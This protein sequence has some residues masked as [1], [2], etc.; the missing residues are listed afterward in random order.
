MESESTMHHD[1]NAP[2][3]DLDWSSR[4]GDG[5]LARMT[6]W[7]FC[8]CGWESSREVGF[9]GFG[10]VEAAAAAHATEHGIAFPGVAD[11]GPTDT[12]RLGRAMA[13]VMFAAWR[14]TTATAAPEG[15]Q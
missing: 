11:V 6:A 13:R 4:V 3:H 12:Q 7:Y 8:S 14:G 15:D 2:A 9:G 5:G 10:L 1:D